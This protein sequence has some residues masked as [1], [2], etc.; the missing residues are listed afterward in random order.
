MI[1]FLSCD[2]GT[3]SFRLRLVRVEDRQILGEYFSDVGV[4]QAFYSYKESGSGTEREQFYLDLLREGVKA[5][6]RKLNV[7][8]TETMILCSGMASS[9]IGIRELP[10]AT[11][12]F[13]VNGSTME[14][15]FYRSGEVMDHPIFLLSGVKSTRDV[16]RGEE[17]QLIGVIRQLPS[18]SGQGVFIFPGTHSKHIYVSSGEITDFKT[19]MT[20]EVFQL[21]SQNSLLSD[22]IS[23]GELAGS[24]LGFAFA[25]G[26]E[27][28]AR[29][30]LLGTLFQVRANEL[31]GKLSKAENFHYLS[32]LLIG[33]ELSNLSTNG[34]FPIYLCA[35]GALHLTYSRAMEILTLNAKILTKEEVRQAV[36]YGQLEIFNYTNN[37]E[38]SIFLGSF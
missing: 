5:L 38:K 17:T 2:W 11:L 32:G 28:G 3:S 15:H 6:E 4:K 37:H 8:L 29:N 27:E 18:F 24:E 30:N 34:D 25:K 21:L 26:V 20:G 35:E 19:Y 9:T 23:V 22:S 33:N 16:M 13:P 36:V 31:F 1:R 7:D 14:M 12:P 10:Y